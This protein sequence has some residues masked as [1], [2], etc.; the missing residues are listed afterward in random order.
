MNRKIFKVVYAVL[1][2][3]ILVALVVFMIL[4]ITRG[5]EG[6]MSTLYIL[7]YILLMFWAAIR[8]YSLL[9]DIKNMR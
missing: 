7:M 6:Q 9:K 1:M 4:Q 8:L 5:S 2:A 3:L